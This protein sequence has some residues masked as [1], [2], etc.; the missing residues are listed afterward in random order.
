MKIKSINLKDFKRFTDL[1]IDGLP[2]T[3]KLVVMI[4]PNGSGKSSVFDALNCSTYIVKNSAYPSND[5]VIHPFNLSH[6]MDYYL[7]NGNPV[8]YFPMSVE[9]FLSI[10]TANHSLAF[11]KDIISRAMKVSKAVEVH[12]LI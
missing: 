4:G 2:E 12:T 10:P 6:I 3:A 5:I 11:L 9:D 1:T 7:K 8:P